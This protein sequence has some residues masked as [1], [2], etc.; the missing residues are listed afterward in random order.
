MDLCSAL[1]ANSDDRALNIIC[2]ILSSIPSCFT[3]CVHQMKLM[4]TLMIWQ[5]LDLNRHFIIILVFLSEAYF[6]FDTRHLLE[7]GAGQS[8]QLT[9]YQYSVWLRKEQTQKHV[10]HRWRRRVEVLEDPRAGGEV[11]PLPGHR[12]HLKTGQG[13]SPH[14]GNSPK[15]SWLEETSQKELSLQPDDPEPGATQS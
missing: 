13:A 3:F 12:L 7:K 14:H 10:R 5:I 6:C 2:V 8:W 11:A 9:A 15:P 4:W 1:S